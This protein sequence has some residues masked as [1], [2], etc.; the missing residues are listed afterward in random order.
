MVQV[1][2]NA[3]LKNLFLHTLSEKTIVF[4]CAFVDTEMFLLILYNVQNEKFGSNFPGQG[5]YNNCLLG[6]ET[7]LSTQVYNW[8]LMDLRLRWG[9]RHTPSHLLLQMMGLALAVCAT[10]LMHTLP[11][12]M[13]LLKWA[14][15]VLMS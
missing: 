3:Q 14:R 8:V 1:C 13:V 4:A 2:Y 7:L 6:E 9:I 10:A 11:T 15:E 5:Y 12:C